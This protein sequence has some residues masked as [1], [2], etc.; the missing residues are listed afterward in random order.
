MK[1]EIKEVQIAIK[2]KWYALYTRARFEKKV[3]KRLQE[4][5][6][7]AFLPLQKTLRQWS[8]RK[9]IVEVP[10]FSSYVFVNICKHEYDKV[11]KTDGVVGY[12]KFEGKAVDI[13]VEQINYLKKLINS[14]YE[15]ESTDFPFLPGEQVEI[16]IGPLKGLRGELIR[17]E[18]KSRFLVRMEHLNQNLLVKIPSGYIHYVN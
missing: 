5:K 18:Q 9:K 12:I 14:D 1:D 6:I 4:Q 11:L 16:L 2:K 10:L 8:D 7:E 17:K 15:I 13:P 3:N